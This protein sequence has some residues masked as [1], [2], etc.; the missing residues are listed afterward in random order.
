MLEG[1][2]EAACPLWK[3]LDLVGRAARLRAARRIPILLAERGQMYVCESAVD[4]WGSR[5]KLSWARLEAMIVEAEAQAGMPVRKPV[6]SE[7][8][9]EEKGRKTG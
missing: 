9:I 8:L 2:R 1:R 4:P 7:G 6:G 5:R 3:Q